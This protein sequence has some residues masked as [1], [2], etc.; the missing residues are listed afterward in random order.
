MSKTQKG[1]TTLFTPEHPTKLKNLL[2]IEKNEIEKKEY[3]LD[4]I[5]SNLI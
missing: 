4:K 1:N 5:M 3:K 2:I